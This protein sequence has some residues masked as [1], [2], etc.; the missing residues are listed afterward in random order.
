MVIKSIAE[1]KLKDRRAAKRKKE[2]KL[3]IKDSGKNKS[4][5][6]FGGEWLK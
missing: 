5:S 2:S 3:K 6:S 4:L 1:L